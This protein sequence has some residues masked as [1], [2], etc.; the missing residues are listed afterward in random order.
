[1][2]IDEDAA[3]GADGIHALGHIHVRDGFA[4]FADAGAADVDGGEDAFRAGM[5]RAATVDG[6]VPVTGS[7]G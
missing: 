3:G 2:T 6:D 1:M 5:D 7:P 4:L